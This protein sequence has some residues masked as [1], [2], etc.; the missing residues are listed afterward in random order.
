VGPNRVNLNPA[1]EG[2][3]S[4]Q[5]SRHRDELGHGVLAILSLLATPVVCLRGRSTVTLADCSLPSHRVHTYALI[6]GPAVTIDRITGPMDLLG[7]PGGS[8]S[9]GN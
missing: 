7:Q 4:P 8:H 1:A 2:A 9:H 5:R 3:P 6:P